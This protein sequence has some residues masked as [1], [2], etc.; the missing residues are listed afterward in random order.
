MC[1]TTLKATINISYVGILI[2]QSAEHKASE[3]PKQV[4]WEPVSSPMEVSDWNLEGKG[5]GGEP[6]PQALPWGLDEGEKTP[7][8]GGISQFSCQ[9]N[10]RRTAP[11]LN[12]IKG[13]SSF[14]QPSHQAIFL[15]QVTTC[16]RRET[17]KMSACS[18][19]IFNCELIKS[20]KLSLG[21]TGF[22]G[23]LKF[24]W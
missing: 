22:S 1:I 12:N 3:I 2:L 15:K 21:V 18:N 16:H 17:S 8:S 5:A 23:E 19:I 14:S 24:T 6:G 20:Q 4:K 7:D 13:G 10:K 11:C 9:F